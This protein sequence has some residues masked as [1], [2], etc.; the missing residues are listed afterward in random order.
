[1]QTFEMME[2]EIAELKK[3]KEIMKKILS[4]LLSEYEEM[5]DSEFSTTKNQTPCKTDPICIKA[6]EVLNIYEVREALK[7]AGE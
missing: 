5:L 7:E 1:M 2:K 4:E 6:R 3:Q